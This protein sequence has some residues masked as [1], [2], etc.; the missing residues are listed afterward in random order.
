MTRSLPAAFATAVVLLACGA[1]PPVPE[2]APEAATP[3]ASTVPDDCTTTVSGGGDALDT[4]LRAAE[5]GAVVCVQPGVYTGS[6]VFMRSATVKALGDGVILDAGGEGPVLGVLQRG[7]R[8]ELNGLTLRN[9]TAHAGGVLPLEEV[10]E[11]VFVNCTMTGNTASDYGGGAVF[12][13]RGKV[14]LDGCTVT[15]N[16]GKTG[17]ALLA[18]GASYWEI[19]GT[20]VTGNEGVH[21]GGMAVREGAQVEMD[22]STVTGN[23]ASG[24]GGAQIYIDG[25][26]T[27][28]PEVA[29]RTST[30]QGGEPAIHVGSDLATVVRE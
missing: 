12:A 29:I 5:A 1:S 28:A 18:D 15:G 2:P 9:G 26:T 8:V 3:G 30:V 25:S 11:V 7:I 20:K 16:K 14:V 24:E 22:G 19:R 17:G 21:G 4:A 6:H 27:Q 13:R 10:A 23:T